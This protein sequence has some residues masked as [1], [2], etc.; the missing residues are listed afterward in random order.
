MPSGFWLNLANRMHHLEEWQGVYFP[1]FFL[2]ALLWLAVSLYQRPQLLLG[3][4]SLYSYFPAGNPYFL[5]SFWL[6]EWQWVPSVAS[7]GV[8]CHPWLVSSNPDDSFIKQLLF[9]FLY[10]Y[11]ARVAIHFLPGLRLIKS[12]KHVKF[13]LAV[14]VC[15]VILCT[16]VI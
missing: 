14:S 13:H 9:F 6:Q 2:A 1:G 4:I 10:F 11:L 7:S 3:S 5:F 16:W 12:Q 8:P 15:E